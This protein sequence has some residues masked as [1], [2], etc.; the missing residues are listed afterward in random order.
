[1]SQNDS[2]RIRIAIA[3]DHQLVRDGFRALLTSD[4]RVEVVGEAADGIQAVEL[5]EK[6]KPAV[7]LLDLRIPR[8]HGL[9]VLRQLR[10]QK[11]TRVLIVTMHSDEPYII[12]A[13]KNG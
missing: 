12:E 4:S 9:E 3:E 7:L 8:L 5:V 6:L 11:A 2:S 13:L 1:M 10:G